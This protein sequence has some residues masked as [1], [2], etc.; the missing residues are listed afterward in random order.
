MRPLIGD[1]PLTSQ[2]RVAKYHGTVKGRLQHLMCNI[3]ERS[4]RFGYKIEIDRDYLLSIYELQKGLCALT[5]EPFD[6]TC[7]N[8]GVV[9]PY[10]MSIDRI[11]SNLGYVPG[12]V[13]IV[14]S[15]ANMAKGRWTDI[16]LI[17]FCKQIVENNT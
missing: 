5:N 14:C 16:E 13:R 6:L 1:K 2:E 12:N 9:N 3:R 8:G 15:M 11:D 4:K 7:R 10:S 17:K